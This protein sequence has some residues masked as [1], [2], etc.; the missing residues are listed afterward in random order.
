MSCVFRKKS[1]LENTKQK[2]V[3]VCREEKWAWREI[4]ER[5]NPQRGRRKKKAS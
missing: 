2:L 5:K 4:G 1:K 3:G